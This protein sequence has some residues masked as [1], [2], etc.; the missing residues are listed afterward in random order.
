[1]R[2][3][4]QVKQRTSNSN[5]YDV[6]SHVMQYGSKNIT[7]EKLYLYLGFDPASVNL[8]PNNGQLEKPMEVVNQRDADIFYMWQ[9]VSFFPQFLFHHHIYK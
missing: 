5:N 1:M 2:E 9:M 8:P 6:G 7:Q 4:L 3:L